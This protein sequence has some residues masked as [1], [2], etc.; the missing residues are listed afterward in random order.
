MFGRMHQMFNH[1]IVCLLFFFQF[2]INAPIIHIIA[3]ANCRDILENPK[4]IKIINENVA[5]DYPHSSVKSLDD[6]Y[7]QHY[8]YTEVPLVC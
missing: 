1:I 6:K 4:V 8:Y 5:F 3:E 7:S 2:C